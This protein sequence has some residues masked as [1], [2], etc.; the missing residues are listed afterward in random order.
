MAYEISCS[1]VVPWVLINS[2][3][4][5]TSYKINLYSKSVMNQ[6][7]HKNIS[8]LSY[9]SQ[10]ST[11]GESEWNIRCIRYNMIYLEA[12]EQQGTECQYNSVWSILTHRGRV[13][14]ICVSKLTNIGSDNGLAPTRRQAIIWTNVGILLI[15]PLGTNFSEI[16]IE[17]HIFSFKK[18]DL[19]MSSGNWQP[20]CLSLNVLSILL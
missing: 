10:L 4:P 12:E 1:E 18:I 8:S 20:S 15:G 13:T 11:H 3:H 2:G 5:W 19:K 7:Q 9:Q 17:I 14:H 6:Q 16:S